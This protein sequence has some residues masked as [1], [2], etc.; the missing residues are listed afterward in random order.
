MS[1]R[2]R[3]GGIKVAERGN[4]VLSHD[5]A[6]LYKTQDAAYLRTVA[7][8]TTRMRE[9]LEQS[10]VVEEDA[11]VPAVSDGLKSERSHNHVAF[12]DSKAEQEEWSGVNEAKGL[13][14]T[15]STRE[16]DKHGENIESK[17][18]KRKR[19]RHREATRNMLAALRKREADLW[20]AERELDIQ[21]AKMNNQPAPRSTKDGVKFKIK[22]RKR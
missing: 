12:V 13:N 7:Q 6:K 9:K 19:R 10:L 11:I 14:S 5:V 21:R 17:I 16:Q 22:E 2:T 8:R 1:S 18:T 20:T 4:Q 3:D 15:R